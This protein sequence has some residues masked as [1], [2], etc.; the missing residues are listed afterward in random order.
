L[1]HCEHAVQP[2]TFTFDLPEHLVPY[3]K[4]KEFHNVHEPCLVLGTL[5]NTTAIKMKDIRWFLVEED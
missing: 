5:P 2:F 4:S 1:P 3:L